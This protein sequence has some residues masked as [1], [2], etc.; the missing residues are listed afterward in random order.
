MDEFSPTVAK[1]KNGKRNKLDIILAILICTKS[2]VKKTHVMFKAR[3]NSD[4]LKRY[5][6]FLTGIGL[7]EVTDSGEYRATE[8]GLYVLRV[9]GVINEEMS[10]KRKVVY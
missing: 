3:I 5:L 2:P 6:D 8:S 1:T 4:Q 10:M 7:L 9:F